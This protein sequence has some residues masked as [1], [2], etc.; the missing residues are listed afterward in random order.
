MEGGAIADLLQNKYLLL[1][2]GQSPIKRMALRKWN[3]ATFE[4]GMQQS[5]VQPSPVT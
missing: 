3:Y 2:Y 4:Q 5:D 1:S